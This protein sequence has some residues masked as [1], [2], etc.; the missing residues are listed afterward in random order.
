MIYIIL[1]KL[2]IKYLH[3]SLEFICDEFNLNKAA[4]ILN[5]SER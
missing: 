3:F 2:F 5:L 4:S 1:L